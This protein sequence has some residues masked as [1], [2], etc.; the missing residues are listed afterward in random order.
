[1]PAMPSTSPRMSVKADVVAACR[2]G[3]GSRTSSTGSRRASRSAGRVPL[4]GLAEHHLDDPLG[5]GLLG[6]RSCPRSRPSRSTDDGVGDLRQFLQAVRD[7][8]DGHA[9]VGQLRAP[10]GTAAR[11]RAGPGPRSARPAS[12]RAGSNDIAL[13]ISTTCCW[14]M[15]SR[16]TL[17][18]DVQLDAACSSSTAAAAAEDRGPV[19]ER[20]VPAGAVAAAGPRGCSRPRSAPAPGSVPGRRWRCPWEGVARRAEADRAAVHQDLPAGGLDRAGEDLH[21]RALAGPVLADQRVDRPPRTQSKRRPGPWCRGRPCGFRRLAV[22]L[23][24]R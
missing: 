1:M 7:V 21:Q 8:D 5:R 10:G 19:D 11:P 14:A 13:A 20:S 24:W 22:C 23:P 9:A 3:R 2:R 17:R 12:A 18:R 4:D 6:C 16:P 15:P